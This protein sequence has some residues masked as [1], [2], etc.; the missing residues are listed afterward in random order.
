M[1]VRQERER[2]PAGKPGQ[3]TLPELARQLDD[4]VRQ[5][6]DL[7]ELR[8]VAQRRRRLAAQPLGDGRDGEIPGRRAQRGGDMAERPLR[9][10]S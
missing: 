5:S 6:A 7:L 10:S 9:R 4:E 3:L 8:G 1:G 2:A